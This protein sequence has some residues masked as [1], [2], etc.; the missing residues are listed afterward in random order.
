MPFVKPAREQGMLQSEH[1]GLA[2]LI[3]YPSM[4]RYQTWYSLFLPMPTREHRYHLQN[5]V[6]RFVCSLYRINK[7]IV[8]KTFESQVT[9]Q[10]KTL[11]LFQ[12]TRAPSTAKAKSKYKADSFKGYSMMPSPPETSYR[13][14]KVD[15]PSVDRSSGS[16]RCYPQATRRRERELAG[17]AVE[18]VQP[19]ALKAAEV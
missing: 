16:S 14:R 19:K 18:A 11:I 15:P 3:V 12:M 7:N 17:P 5:L 9:S 13:S 10:R 4:P 6:P 8:T 2:N 1:K